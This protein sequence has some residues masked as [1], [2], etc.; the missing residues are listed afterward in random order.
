[1]LPILI[2]K[3]ETLVDTVVPDNKNKDEVTSAVNAASAS[4][5]S[6]SLSTA[7][8][9]DV[10]GSLKERVD[11][12][13]DTVAKSGMNADVIEVSPFIVNINYIMRNSHTLLSHFCKAL[14]E[15]PAGLGGFKFSITEKVAAKGGGNKE[16]NV[17][18]VVSLNHLI[19]FI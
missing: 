5:P 3:A 2:F 11:L 9:N 15:I 17:I 1:M 18:I 19:S 16:E 4:P 8:G 12:Y 14:T 13:S 7:I 10:P 6:I